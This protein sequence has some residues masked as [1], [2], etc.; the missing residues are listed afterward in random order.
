MQSHRE[1]RDA[2][3]GSEDLL[4]HVVDTFREKR[5]P[6]DAV[7]YLGS[8]FT[9]TGWNTPQPS[10]DF[11]RDV[12][13]RQPDEVLADLHAR[14]VKVITHI[15]PW[16]RGR[17]R[18]LH[19]TVPP[20]QGDVLDASH[21]FSYWQEH[22]PLVRA[23]VDAWWPDEG[24]WF[25]LYER[26]RRHELYCE[27]PLWTTPG[28][29]PWSLHRNGHVGVAQ[30]DGWIWSGDPQGTWKTLPRSPWRSSCVHAAVPS[31]DERQGRTHHS[32]QQA[33]VGIRPRLPQL[34]LRAPVNNLL[35]TRPW[36]GPS[37]YDSLKE[38]NDPTAW[39][40]VCTG[41]CACRG[42]A[43]VVIVDGKT[44]GNATCHSCRSRPAS[45]AAKSLRKRG[46][47]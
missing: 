33:G 1:L 13:E 24:D 20:A 37:R 3:L 4:L 35:V 16:G 23:G 34:G 17:L 32:D 41:G 38:G 11:N 14:N 44:G 30:W 25:D 31:P 10:F 45:W 15:V 47:W 8:G 40:V 26:I 36:V 9:P 18:T 42:T 12:F 21:V 43:T 27:G 2:D 46:L 22:V 29:R 19:G 7:I 6:L 5:I 28:V 39:P